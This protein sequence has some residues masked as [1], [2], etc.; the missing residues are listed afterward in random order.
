MTR[1]TKGLAALCLFCAL[2]LGA[3][4]AQGAVAAIKGT[5]GFTCKKLGPG[6]NFTGAH[7]KESDFK[8]GAGEYEHIAI[9]ANTKTEGQI[10]SEITGGE[11]QVGKLMSVIAGVAV[12]MQA[13]TAENSA[14][15]ENK[16]TEAGEHFSE[17]TGFTSF[18]G[19]TVTKP[20]GKGCK[21]KG[22][23][24]VT[25]E[26]RGTSLGQGMEGKLEPV[27][28]TLFAKFEIEGCSVAALNG[29]YEVKGS[30]KCPGDGATV[31]CT[32]AATTAQGTLTMRGSKTGVEVTTTASARANSTEPYTPV[33]VTTIETP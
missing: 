8:A 4:T 33:A 10:S 29:V 22:E 7:C 26:L 19:I 5:T 21:V 6:H 16:V 11:T 2:F 13:T 31:I 3:L 28:G 27:T 1:R 17:G 9:A 15:G 24:V 18:S 12:E 25:T 20:A 14:T 23:K 30:I 32:D